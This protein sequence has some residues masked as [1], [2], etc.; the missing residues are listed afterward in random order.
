MEAKKTLIFRIWQV[1]ENYSDPDHPL[2]QQRVIKYLEDDFGIECERKAV[3]RNISYLK[4]MGLDIETDSRGT[5]LASRQFEPSELRLLIDSVLG[6]KHINAKYSRELIDKLIKL[7]GNNFKSHV[8]HVHS[9]KEWSKSECKD[10]FFNIDMIDEAIERGKKISFFYN[11]LDINKKLR[12][13]SAHTGSP[14]TLLLHNQRYY[15]MLRD[16]KYDKVS[17]LRMDKI[18]DMRILAEDAIP[19]SENEGFK[20]GIN[21]HE[22]ST[23]LPYMYSDKKAL[24]TLRCPNFMMDDLCD[25]FGTDFAVSKADEGHFIATVNASEQAML[26]W[27]LQYNVNAEVLS[28]ASLREKVLSAL[29]AAVTMYES[30]KA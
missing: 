1:I 27:A 16:D 9:V 6:S 12:P 11:H 8:R 25:W 14:Y 19:I 21:Y 13:S 26:Y 10:L 23:G 17:Y 24:V 3:S 20:R 18:T 5:Y 15:V 4:E 28:P 2:T 22:L 30:E 29:K 7:G